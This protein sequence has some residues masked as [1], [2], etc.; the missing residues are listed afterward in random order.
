LEGTVTSIY[1]CPSCENFFTYENWSKE[2]DI[3]NICLDELENPN[4]NSF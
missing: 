4:G 1:R 2:N 3:C